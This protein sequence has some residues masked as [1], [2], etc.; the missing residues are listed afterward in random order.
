MKNFGYY[1]NNIDSILENSFTDSDKFKRNLSVV[2][3]AMKYSKI[4]REFFTL[5]NEI[6]NKHFENKDDSRNYINEA[7][8]FLKSNKHKLNKVTP[9]LNKIILDRKDLC[10]KKTNKIYENIDN[11]VFNN[12]ITNLETIS[13]SKN[14]LTENTLQTKKTTTKIKNPK[15][16]SHVLSKNYGEAYNESLTENEQIILKNTLLMTEDSLSSEFN[17]VKEITV[18]KING[19]LKESKDDSLSAKLVEVKNEIKGLNTT[20]KSYI[21]VRSLLEDLN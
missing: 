21:R 6:E 12:S 4:L 1:K 18:N 11:V 14:F 8:D 10:T 15:I 9:I 20:K 2:M 16:L 7:V 19:L 3:G 17:N 13:E 5:Y